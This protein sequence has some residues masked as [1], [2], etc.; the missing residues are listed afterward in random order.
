MAVEKLR[1]MARLFNR[2]GNSLPATVHDNDLDADSAHK[3]DIIHQRLKILL[4]FHDAA[5]ELYKHDRTSKIENIRQG[6][7]QNR[8]L[9]NCGVYFFHII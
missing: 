7:G 4:D 3:S 6:F 9:R 2:L 5:A 1:L 8:R